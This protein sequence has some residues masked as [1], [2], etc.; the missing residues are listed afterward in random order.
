M[1]WV[2]P[3]GFG[4]V[5]GEP[6]A[7]ADDYEPLPNLPFMPLPAV[8]ASQPNL[9]GVQVPEVHAPPPNLTGAPVPE[10][11]VLPHD[12]ADSDRESMEF[13]DDAPPPGSPESGHSDPPPTSPR[14]ESSTESNLGSD[15]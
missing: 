8:H 2:G 10:A 1:L 5:W 15:H 12:P 14:A 6:E 13:D 3:W 11:H 4:N 7:D 9:A